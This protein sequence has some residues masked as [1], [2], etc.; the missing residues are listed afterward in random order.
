MRCPE[1]AELMDDVDFF[2]LYKK[3]IS[4]GGVTSEDVFNVFCNYVYVCWM[5]F[6]LLFWPSSP[7]KSL[8]PI[9]LI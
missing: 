2:F 1:C 3:K 4:D 9:C 7:L 6:C 5:W 8:F